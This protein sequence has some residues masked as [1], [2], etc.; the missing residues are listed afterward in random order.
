MNPEIAHDILTF[1]GDPADLVSLFGDRP[2]ICLLESSLQDPLL[3][4]RSFL[5]VDPYAVVRGVDATPWPRLR[6]ELGGGASDPPSPF[7]GGAMG[8]LGYDWGRRREFDEAPAASSD[9]TAGYVFF[10]YDVVLTV[11]HAARRLIVTSTGLPERAAAARRRRARSRLRDVLTRLRRGPS[12]SGGGPEGPGDGFSLREWTTDLDRSAYCG[13]IARALGL[14]RDGEI[15]Q[16]NLARRFWRPRRGLPEPFDVYRALRRIAPAPFGGY[17]NAGDVH[18]VSSSPERFLRLR[19]GL[20][21]TRPMKGTR[22]RGGTVEE[23]GRL[24]RELMGSAKDAA[25]LLMIVDLERNDLGKVCRFG[26]VTVEAMRTLEAY[27]RVFQTTATVL[28]RLRPDCDAAAA[29][30]ACFPGGSITGCPK[31]RAM[32]VIDLLE[33][34][35]RGMYTGAMGY[36]GIGGTMD[37]NVLIR[38]LF[39]KEDLV[40]FHVGG[41]IVADS[42][43]EGEYEETIV[44]AASLM[45]RLQGAAGPR[46]CG[47]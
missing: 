26:S 31:R 14:I 46:G 29:L 17:L 16:V 7:P 4:G 44:K 24:R 39:F 20:L 47:V 6:A 33:P 35:P 41:G 21:E 23:D 40:E 34:V 15:Y 36:L 8:V 42:T 2:G 1:D 11:D 12:V 38:T 18:V 30:D 43:P 28:G 25:E 27:A 45:G 13:R 5:G 37:F 19:G 22:P 32:E 9:G 3:G 10:L